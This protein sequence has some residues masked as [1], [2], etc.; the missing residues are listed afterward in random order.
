MAKVRQLQQRDWDQLL[1]VASG[2]LP[3]TNGDL[4]ARP[5]HARMRSPLRAD[6]QPFARR[7]SR[8]RC[9]VAR[10]P[11]SCRRKGGIALAFESNEGPAGARGD[12][13]ARGV[14][15]SSASRSRPTSCSRW[16]SRSGYVQRED[17]DLEPTPDG[18]WPST[19]ADWPDVGSN[20]RSGHAAVRR[21]HHPRPVP[22]GHAWRIIPVRPG[23]FVNLC[24]SIALAGKMISS[25][26]Q[27]GR[28]GRHA[29]GKP[30]RSTSRASSC[31]SS[32]RYANETFNRRARAP[33][34]TPAWWCPRKR[35]SPF[36]STSGGTQ[37]ATWSR[38]IP[39]DGSSNI[40]VNATIG[41]IF[42]VFRRKSAEGDA[43]SSSPMRCSTGR[44][45]H[46]GWLHHL[47]VGHRARAGVFEAG[48]HGFTLDPTV[49]EF[50]LLPPEHPDPRP[51]RPTAATK[52]TRCSWSARDST[53][54][55]ITPRSRASSARYIGS[56]VADFH[57][58]L[59]KGGVFLY[60]ADT[61]APQG[62]LRLL[63][64]GFPLAFLAEKAG[65]AATDGRRPILDLV[66]D[67]L[68]QRTP[69]FI[70]GQSLVQEVTRL[71]SGES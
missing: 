22:D 33:R 45:L 62:K 34:A 40:D 68:H 51:A 59:L 70:G 42:G 32:I 17:D 61:Q 24:Q 46:R 25:S 71:I 14:Q 20:P 41:T 36:W 69:L 1:I 19:L 3:L 12:S 29:W 64:E 10:S 31:R 11:C 39:L 43:G 16:W 53:G 37:V 50:F 67:E 60:P 18:D 13:D 2:F 52:P 47:R 5:W 27:P 66:P 49:G 63:Y 15:V 26:R 21:G 35:T 38:S 57:R 8:P 65:G 44:D 30:E 58:N 48:V 54:S 9:P 56:L 7:G 55:S 6:P 4:Q 28:S 23:T